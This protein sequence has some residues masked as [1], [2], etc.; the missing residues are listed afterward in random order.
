MIV[1]SSRTFRPFASDHS[2]RSSIATRYATIALW[3]FC[4]AS[5]RR[6]QSSRAG[7][8]ERPPAGERGE[9]GAIGTCMRS[10]GH[11]LCGLDRD[12]F[13]AGVRAAQRVLGDRQLGAGVLW[14]GQ[15]V[16]EEL[17]LVGA[18]SAP[19]WGWFARIAM[20]TGWHGDLANYSP[21]AASRSAERYSSLKTR[22][23]CSWRGAPTRACT[24]AVDPRRVAVA[25]AALLTSIAGETQTHHLMR[26]TRATTR[27][28]RLVG[29]LQVHPGLSCYR[30][31]SV[32]ARCVG[33]RSQS[34][35]VAPH[36]L[37]RPIRVVRGRLWIFWWRRRRRRRWV[38]VRLPSRL[39][40]TFL[41]GDAHPSRAGEWGVVQA[42]PRLR[43][44]PGR[45]RVGVE[46][47]YRRPGAG[48]R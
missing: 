43:C 39:D 38:A 34:S 14:L 30:G 42:R 29:S 35:D 18:V 5:S 45:G 13:Q 16:V 4:W 44:H 3:L 8:S 10:A 24:S 11:G 6:S 40:E 28:R 21:P 20:P 37:A 17:E 48:R 25:S 15:R 26:G 23:E 36:D 22:F 12:D 47:R 1:A 46:H 32:A 19:V 41:R 33:G 9:R 2:S 31:E 7:R 27:R